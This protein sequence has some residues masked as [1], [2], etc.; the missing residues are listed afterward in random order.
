M[1]LEIERSWT[2]SA[3]LPSRASLLMIS[4]LVIMTSEPSCSPLHIPGPVSR[5]VGGA[6]IQWHVQQPGKSFTRDLTGFR[7][8]ITSSNM[9]TL[10]C[11]PKFERSL[12]DS[13]P[14]SLNLGA[15]VVSGRFHWKCCQAGSNQ[16]IVGCAEAFRAGQMPDR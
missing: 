8:S 12:S 11:W 15:P 5:S 1:S 3:S 4:S 14:L 13:S 7:V 10:L 9:Q 16:P 2:S 6:L